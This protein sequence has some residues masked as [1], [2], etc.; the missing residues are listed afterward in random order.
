MKG[1]IEITVGGGSKLVTGIQLYPAVAVARWRGFMATAQQQ[2]GGVST[3]LGFWGSPGWAIGGAVVLGLVES[4][5]SSAKAKEGIQTLETANKLLADIRRKA[6]IFDLDD[7]E[8]VAVP[9]PAG[10]VAEGDG[11]KRV[12]MNSVPMLSRS[13]FLRE[14]GLSTAD[15]VNGTVKVPARVKF[16]DLGEEFVSLRID[17]EDA[18]INVRWAAVETFQLSQR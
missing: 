11:F 17:E 6:Q 18:P 3:G 12:A 2:L 13:A 15:V 9:S 5:L 10:W 16:V 1:R 8:N 7:V 4:A 14:N